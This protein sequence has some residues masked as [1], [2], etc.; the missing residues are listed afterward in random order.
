MLIGRSAILEA[1][2]GLIEQAEL[3]ET[4]PR[5]ALVSGDA[6]VGKSRMV[7]EIK[8]RTVQRGWELLQ[9]NCFE[10]DRTLPYAPFL[11]MLQAFCAKNPVDVITAE[12]AQVAPELIPLLPDLKIYF[13]E[14]DTTPLLDPD[15]E[16]HRIFHA[17]SQFFT[18]L[19]RSRPR[20]IVIEDLQ[21]TD[22]TSLEFIH[23]LARRLS[24]QP[25]SYALLLTFRSE[26]L[27]PVLRHFLAELDRNR[28]AREF[29]LPLLTRDEVSSMLRSI[30]EQPRPVRI[31]FLNTIYELTEGNPF[32]IEEVLKSLLVAGDIFYSAKDGIWDRKPMR[33]LRIPRS[34]QD[35]VHRRTEHLSL[36]ARQIMILAAVIGRGFHFSHLQSLADLI[37]PGRYASSE[38]ELLELLKELINAQLLVEEA[39]DQFSF[40]H[41]LIRQ[42]VYS[43]LLA[44]ERQSLHRQVAE[45]MEFVYTDSAHIDAHLE[46]LSYHFF[47]AADWGKALIYAQ[48]AGHKARKL[49]ASRQ[50]IDHF[51]R[52]LHAAGQIPGEEPFSLYQARGQSYKDLDQ[53]ERAEADYLAALE[54]AE[55]SGDQRKVWS[56]L[57]DLGLLWSGHDYVRGGEY[58]RSALNI[59]RGLNNPAI[60]AH[61][62]NRIGNWNLNR[63]NPTQALGYHNEALEIFEGL[64]DKHGIAQTLDLLGIALYVGGDLINGSRR[65]EQSLDLFRELHDRQGMI[66]SLTYLGVRSRFTTEV[67]GVE[68]LDQLLPACETGLQ[69][70]REIGWRSAESALICS[71]AHCLTVMGEYGMALDSGQAA[72]EIAEDIQHFEWICSASWALGSIYHHLFHFHEAQSLLEKALA[73]ATAIRSTLYIQD[74]SATLALNLIALGELA[75]AQTVLDGI[76]MPGETWETWGLRLCQCSYAELELARGNPERALEIVDGLIASAKNI[77]AAG[78]RSIPRLAYLR[79]KA[80]A[81]L[82]MAEDAEIELRAARDVAGLQAR[83]PLLWRAHIELG[84]VLLTL[85]Q[86]DAAQVEFFAAQTLVEELAAGISDETLGSDFRR[87]AG[88]L[89]PTSPLQTPRQAAKLKYDGLTEREREV[90]VLVARGKSNREIAQE[91]VVSERTAATHI[92]NI[93]NKLDFSSRVQIAA[94]ALETGLADQNPE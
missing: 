69:L 53:F 87:H 20:L 29:R 31:E 6:G 85:K 88:E 74:V 48:K 65:Y 28:F 17:L 8:S 2:E 43:Q 1:F 19:I 61:T 59:A 13:P 89:I 10:T 46:E 94:W 84:K 58:F 24:A 64:Q 82:D 71:L 25:G 44:R 63:G 68:S 73:M 12:F 81:G 76:L 41:T 55:S 5:I 78:R 80:L 4:S 77:A 93:L 52:A 21:W 66:N 92:S 39:G 70:A 15:P 9:G 33:E 45:M 38:T 47:E 35:A 51:S 83:K 30:F 49:Y 27:H 57:L 90:A 7:T 18:Q 23:Y 22:D 72:L 42:A 11:D 3:E 26:E 62:L 14:I 67:L 60:L 32:F 79:G 37:G 40:R 34:V 54:L 75:Q 16:K 36:P 91:L 86:D 56:A 50:A